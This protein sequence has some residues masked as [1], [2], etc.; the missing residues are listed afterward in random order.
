[1][2][3][4]R[5]IL[6]QRCQAEGLIYPHFADRYAEHEVSIEEADYD[7][8]YCG[9]DIGRT[10]SAH[11]F[12][13]T[14]M[15]VDNSKITVLYSRKMPAKD[16][17]PEDVYNFL[18][19]CIAEVVEM[20]GHVDITWFEVAEQV[21]LRG[22][23][24]RRPDLD[25]RNCKKNQVKLRVDKT[26]ELISARKLFYTPEAYT[27]RDALMSCVWDEKKL[28]ATRLDNGSTDVDTLDA[29]EYSYEE[30]LKWL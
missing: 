5:N 20:S 6:G 16:T 24:A 17:D 12:V 18:D 9:V 8:I 28:E 11:T 10:K 29:F 13:A 4:R 22:W 2:W 7:Y 14:G 26:A 21:L 25:I 27:V 23:R 3:F 1:M 30:Q 19:Q 15:K